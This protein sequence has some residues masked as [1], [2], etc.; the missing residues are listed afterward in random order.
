M[1]AE[2]VMHFCMEEVPYMC[3]L[4]C[5]CKIVATSAVVRPIRGK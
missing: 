2:L 5:G 1:Y 3:L 4:N